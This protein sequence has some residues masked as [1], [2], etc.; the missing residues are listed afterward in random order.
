MKETFLILITTIAVQSIACD[1]SV[2][3]DV[4]DW[5]G[6]GL[7]SERSDLIANFGQP[8][9]LLVPENP[10]AEACDEFVYYQGFRFCI[11]GGVV[12]SFDVT[13]TEYIETL[14]VNKKCIKGQGDTFFRL[15]DSDCAI[16][17]KSKNGSV[18]EVI[19]FCA[20]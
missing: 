12:D 6:I 13:S 16:R 8:I 4:G 17:I 9:E 5:M 7:G 20:P 11:L 15:G 10:A 14:A 19:N 18:V 1:D 3:P 2:P